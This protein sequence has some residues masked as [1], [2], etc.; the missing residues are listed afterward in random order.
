MKAKKSRKAPAAYTLWGARLKGELA[1]AD[2][3]ISGFEVIFSEAGGGR[4]IGYEAFKPFAMTFD[5][6]RK[7]VSFERP[8]Q[9]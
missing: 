3:P 5:Q 6:E 7:L 9:R 4:L 2:H 8:A 1:L